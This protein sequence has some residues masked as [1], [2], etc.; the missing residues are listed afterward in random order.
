MGNTNIQE[1]SCGKRIFHVT[2]ET[3]ASTPVSKLLCGNFIEVGFG[4]QVESMW[5]EM[6]FNRSFEKVFP[7]MKGTYDWFGGNDKGLPNDWQ[8][9]EWYHSSYQHSRWYAFPGIDRPECI[10][11]DSSYLIERTHGFSLQLSLEKGGVHGSHYLLIDNYDD[12]W[13]G[14]AQNGKRIYCQQEYHFSGYFRSVSGHPSAEIRMYETDKATTDDPFVAIPIENISPDGT[15]VDLT[16]SSGAFDGWATFAVLIP[17][18]SQMMLDAFSLMPVQSVHGW[19]PDVVEALKELKPSVLRFPGGNFA[20]LHCWMDAIGPRNSRKPEPSAIWGDLNYNDVGTDEFL[21]LCEEIHAEP[22]LLINMYHPRKQFYFQSFPEILQFGGLQRHG[23]NVTHVLDKEEGIE[24][25]R[26]WVEYC[27]GDINTPMGMLRAANGHPEP[28]HVKYWEMDNETWRWFTK[29]EYADYVKRYAAAMRSVDPTIQIGVIS[30]HT[31]SD[32]IEDILDMCGDAVD[33]I[34]DRMCEP[35][36]IK[37]KI[38]IVR[39][40][41]ATHQH[42]IYYTDT[43]AL[44]NRPLTLAPFTSE[45][46]DKNN[47]DFCQSRRT[48]IYALTMAGNLMHY[49]RYGELARFMCF[50]NLCNTSGQ[51][52]IE[53]SKEETILSAAGRRMKAFA[54]TEAA[55]PLRIEGYEADSLKSIEMQVSWNLDRTKLVINLVNKCD[56]EAWITLDLSK[57]AIQG[58]SMKTF[59]LVGDGAAQETIRNHGNIHESVTYRSIDTTL[60][61]TFQASAFSFQEIVIG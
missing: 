8:Q 15:W 18:E 48:W 55:W 6:L 32:V 28:Y 49:E 9:E 20:S 45:Y 35:Y 37:R 12:R 43:E 33:F 59:K 30:Y 24:V 16:F 13:A 53:V 36:N 54:N 39:K 56:E 52:C 42:Q 23:L 5:T 19:R 31:F 10:V 27:N 2:N 38:S 47:I 7:I 17:G 57:L 51:S 4:Y 41:N 21:R 22:M 26:K 44:Q 60:P 3:Y 46:Y 40:Y 58:N 34:A 11:P 50:N 25:A 61:Y 14:V 1:F 29:E